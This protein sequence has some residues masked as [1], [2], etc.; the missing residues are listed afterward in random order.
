[1]SIYKHAEAKVIAELLQDDWHYSY[2]KV[3]ILLDFKAS[4]GGCISCEEYFPFRFGG[5]YV[6]GF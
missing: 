6:R 5:L 2:S 3:N 1:M 4:L